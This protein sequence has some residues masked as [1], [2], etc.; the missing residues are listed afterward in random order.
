MNKF[1]TLATAGLLLFS[2]QAA[3]AQQEVKPPPI[4][5]LLE[6][7]RPLDHPGIQE[8]AAPQPIKEHKAKPKAKART[9][10]KTSKKAY[11]RSSK[12]AAKKRVVKKESHA[13]APRVARKKVRKNHKNKNSETGVKHRAP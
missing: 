6:D 13:K 9:K 12:G 4:P 8:K 7:Q 2:L 1:I 10:A 3:R 5:P 11:R